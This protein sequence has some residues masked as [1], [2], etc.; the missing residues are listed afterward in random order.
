MA[1]KLG[2]MDDGRPALGPPRPR[3]DIVPLS[4]SPSTSSPPPPITLGLYDNRYGTLLLVPPHEL[5]VEDSTY[6]AAAR[7]TLISSPSPNVVI[8]GGAN[9]S[10]STCLLFL[11]E[12]ADD[13]RPGG[14]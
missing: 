4:L 8:A 14:S 6:P 7:M 3:L 9:L 11:Q 2:T 12:A 5:T 1:I 13:A 10:I